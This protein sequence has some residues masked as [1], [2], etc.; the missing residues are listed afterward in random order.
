[1]KVDQA[2]F[3]AI[4]SSENA[5]EELTEKL[6][7]AEQ[8]RKADEDTIRRLS[9]DRLHNMGIANDLA[10]AQAELTRIKTTL[11]SFI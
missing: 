10:I 4:A 9:Q 8:A 1:M 11:R 6:A 2:V 5:I 3:A 7:K